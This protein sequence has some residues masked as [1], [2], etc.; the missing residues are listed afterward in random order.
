MGVAYSPAR[1]RISSSNT[2]AYRPSTD[3]YHQELN[4]N[5]WCPDALRDILDYPNCVTIE[6][7]QIQSN[8]AIHVGSM[9]QNEWSD[10]TELMDNYCRDLMD[11]IG[12]SNSELKVVKQSSDAS[13][14][15]TNTYQSISSVELGSIS[16]TTFSTNATVAK[17]RMRWT[18]ELH[19][20]FVEAVNHLGGSERATPKGVLKLMQVDGLTIY[21]VK[22]HLQKYR[23]TRYRTES[24]E[25]R[26]TKRAKA[27]RQLRSSLVNLDFGSWLMSPPHLIEEEKPR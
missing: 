5:P 21:H 4:E 20:R 10:L 27:L 12:S 1:F 18:P 2:R 16:G 8:C 24:S 25:D 22:S 9:K 3:N 15:H 7:G 14:H 26:Q 11:E 13:I 17:P 6:S 19:E 23:T